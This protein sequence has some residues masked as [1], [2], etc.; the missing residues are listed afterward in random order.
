MSYLKPHGDCCHFS[1]LAQEKM[2]LVATR[3]LA[4]LVANAKDLDAIEEMKY[5][6]HKEF[7][8]LFFSQVNL[9]QAKEQ[10]STVT[11]IGEYIQGSTDSLIKYPE[12]RLLF[13][14][15]VDNGSGRVFSAQESA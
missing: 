14:S 1:Y 6:L 4:L 5:F 13:H 7:G 10:L 15:C 9:K 8:H 2:F 3:N 12:N 11:L